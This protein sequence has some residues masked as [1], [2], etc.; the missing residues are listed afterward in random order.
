VVLILLFAAALSMVLHDRTDAAIILLIV[1]VSGLLGYW[2]ERGAAMAVEKL[3]ELVEIRVRVR[4]G[5]T[6][7][8]APVDEVVPGDV[9]LL[10]AGGGI[11]GDCLVLESND[12]CVDEAAL[13]GETFPVDKLPGVLPAE[14]GLGA[15]SNVLYM[16]THVVSGT[17]R[18]A[19]VRTGRDTEFGKISQRLALRREPT[20]FERGV[21]RFGYFL[22]EVT[23][24]MLVGIFAINTYLH[25]PVLDAFLFALALA[26]GLTPQLLP[27]I[28]SVSLSHGAKRMAE[29]K[30]IVKRLASIENLGSMNVFCSDKT[31]T[32]TQG[33]VRLYKAQDMAGEDSER[34]LELA[35]VNSAFETGFANPIDE[36]V[37]NHRQFAL[38]AYVKLDENPYDF[39]RKRLTMLVAQSGRSLMVTKGAFDNIVSVCTTAERPDGSAAAIDEV[40]EQLE[41]RY[42]SL[43]AEGYRVLGLA[44]REMGAATQVRREDEREMRFLGFLVFYDPPK[45]D[46]AATISELD[47]LGVSL[48]IITGDNSLVARS[49]GSSVGFTDPVVV[50]GQELRHMS[51]AALLQKAPGVDIFAEVEPNQKERIL[52]SLKKSG[53]VTGYMGDGINDAPALHA[54]DVSISVDG[55]VDV[56]KEAADIVLLERDLGAVVR[57]VRHGRTTFANTL[58]YIFMA[59]SANFGNMFSMAGASLFLSFLPLLP[60][61]ILLMNLLTDLPA[62]TIASDR[63]DPEIVERPRRWDLGFIRRFMVTFGVLSSAFDYVTFAILLLVLKAGAAEFRTGWFIESVISACLVVLVVRTRRPFYQAMPGWQLLA[64]THVVAVTAV[65][66]PFT[67]LAGVLDFTTAPPLL[68]AALAGVVAAYIGFAEVAKRWFFRNEDRKDLTNRLSSSACA[69]AGGRLLT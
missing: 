29:D 13:T 14:T 65:I 31:G 1:L 12:L 32:L 3:L 59:T 41:K 9:V 54:A 10:A 48:K 46:V 68:L 42:R 5:G 63:V 4:R 6:G 64:A 8:E 16:G 45:E 58:K 37:R 2:Q 50:T 26:V 62:M 53:H 20:D 18:A 22:M 28:V 61:Q 60:H 39:V 36:A 40:R 34:V 44:V 30:V 69:E 56:A 33:V 55:A 27:A 43:S 52:L 7:I 66:L 21:R 35:Y 15:R 24:L 11:P 25:K 17:G 47:R 38:S 23:L 57:G 51:D 49:V 19:V 67:P